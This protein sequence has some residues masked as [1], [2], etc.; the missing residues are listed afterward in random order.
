[1]N[2]KHIAA[3]IAVVLVLVALG[4]LLRWQVVP[5][6]VGDGWHGKALMLNRWT[7]E[8]RL[9]TADEWVPVTKAQ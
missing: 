1:M 5:L 3:A 8:I 9:V 6:N 7:G 4:W 2:P